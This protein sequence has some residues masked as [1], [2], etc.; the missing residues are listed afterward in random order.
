MVKRSGLSV[1][2]VMKAI[3]DQQSF[4]I[5][6]IVAHAEIDSQLLLSETRLSTRV[7]YSRM[8]KILKAGII[9]RK[10]GKYSLTT[11]GEVVFYSLDLIASALNNY[12]RLSALDSLSLLDTFPPS[13][14][15]KT[16]NILLGKQQIG[17]IL[18]GHLEQSKNN[19][20]HAVV[21]SKLEKSIAAKHL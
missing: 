17:I 2:M 6:T 20:Q 5:L 12:W 14:Y 10:K 15:I 4:Y 7:F 18:I 16:I 11:F 19:N 8:S 13:E 3:C 21:Q 9:S 1:S